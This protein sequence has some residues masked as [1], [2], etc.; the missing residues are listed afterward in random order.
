MSDN[1]DAVGI[2]QGLAAEVELMLANGTIEGTMRHLRKDFPALATEA[3][4]AMG[5]GV[6]KL[7]M[8]QERLSLDPPIEFDGSGCVGHGDAL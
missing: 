3:D 5:H 1:G 8:K 6:E 4:A 2:N 7:T